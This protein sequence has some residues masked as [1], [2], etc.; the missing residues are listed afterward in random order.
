MRNAGHAQKSNPPRPFVCV[1]GLM[2]VCRVTIVSAS[3]S[4]IIGSK[5]AHSKARTGRK[6]AILLASCQ[7]ATVAY[8]SM[9][10]RLL[11]TAASTQ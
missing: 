6:N 11:R 10:G 9:S 1:T 4:P 2:I 3:I 7:L 5:S 8:I